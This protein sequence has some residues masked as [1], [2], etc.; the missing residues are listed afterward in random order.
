MALEYDLFIGEGPQDLDLVEILLRV[1]GFAASGK[2]FSGPG[3]SAWVLETDAL[4]SGI[5]REE[6]DLDIRHQISFRVDLSAYNEEEGYEG[7]KTIVTTSLHVL[8]Q[9]SF[10]AALLFNG[11]S[12]VLLRRSGK[13]ILNKSKGFWR[14]CMLSL[15][16][17]PHTLEDLPSL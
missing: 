17:T 14:P 1:P 11:E 2:G 15:V 12:P 13:L 10:D 8:E 16:K 4:R 5:M 7:V 6:F 3:V 9:G